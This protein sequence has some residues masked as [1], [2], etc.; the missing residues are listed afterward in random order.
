MV[1]LVIGNLCTIFMQV[2]LV[3]IV[4]FLVACMLS[5]TLGSTNLSKVN[6][7]STAIFDVTKY[8]AK[9]N[10]ITDDSPVIK[11]YVSL[12]GCGMLSLYCTC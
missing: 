8:G 12:Y 3:T 2:Q 11:L 9:G 7:V 10:G 4:L 5:T 1:F 6:L